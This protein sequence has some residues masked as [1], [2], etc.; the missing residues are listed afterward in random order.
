[1]IG[2]A[3]DIAVGIIGIVPSGGGK[4]CCIGTL[5]DFADD[6]RDQTRFIVAARLVIIGDMIVEGIQISDIKIKGFGGGSAMYRQASRLVT[7]T[8]TCQEYS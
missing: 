1:L 5:A 6:L 4:I 2:N 3:G 8:Q 7:Q